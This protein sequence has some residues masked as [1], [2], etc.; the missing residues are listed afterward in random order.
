MIPI[1]MHLMHMQN[2]NEKQ[3][4]VWNDIREGEGFIVFLSIS[5]E[6]ITTNSYNYLTIILKNSLIENST[7]KK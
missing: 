7:R 4:K 5:S 6:T 3:I 2:I 1:A